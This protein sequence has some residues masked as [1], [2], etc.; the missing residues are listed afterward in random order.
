M[1]DSV[2]D[3]DGQYIVFEARDESERF[4]QVLSVG[5]RRL[6]VE[7]RA[8]SAEELHRLPAVD[9]LAGH[10]VV[11][12]CLRDARGWD[13]VRVDA[14]RTT[15]AAAVEDVDYAATGLSICNALI[16]RAKRR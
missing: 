16:D 14:T 15:A 1:L 10:Q 6:D 2:A 3:G 11:L 4:V 8:S 5:G 7:W 9:V 13:T 12:R